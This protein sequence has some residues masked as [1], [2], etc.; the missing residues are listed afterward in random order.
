[1]AG[2]DDNPTASHA[3]DTV[4]TRRLPHLVIALL[5]SAGFLYLA[6]RNVKLDELGAALQRIN[7]SWLLVAIV[8][9]LLIM[10]F[11]A[12]RWQLELRPLEHVPFGRLWVIISVAYMA[13]NLLPVRI[14]E[15]V[16]PWL[17][18]RKSGV[19]F[20]S[21]VGNVVLEKTM[22]SVIIVFYILLGLV[23]GR[24]S[25]GVGSSW[26]DVPRRGGHNSCNPC[27]ALLVAR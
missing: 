3:N 12:W 20:S 18:S 13:I 2:T 26:S 19:S 5:V 4:A 11:R 24:E 16:R 22:D 1:M 9:S 25:T 10:V 17:L 15:I 6:F 14:G 8:V 27:L 21:V 7:I 23:N